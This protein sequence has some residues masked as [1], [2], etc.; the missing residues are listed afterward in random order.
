MATAPGRT[1]RKLEAERAAIRE[2]RKRATVSVVTG[3]ASAGLGRDGSYRAAAAGQLPVIRLGREL[4]VVS[5]KM[6]AML[7][8]SLTADT[9]PPSEGEP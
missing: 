8:I 9:A 3:G 5:A 1:G 4:R 2:M 6:L 7:G